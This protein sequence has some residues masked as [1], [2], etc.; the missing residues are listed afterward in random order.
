[1]WSVYKAVINIEPHSATCDVGVACDSCPQSLVFTHANK[2]DKV[3]CKNCGTTAIEYGS[4]PFDWCICRS[5]NTKM[6]DSVKLPSS[7]AL[8]LAAASARAMRRL[9]DRNNNGVEGRGFESGP[10]QQQQEESRGTAA[11]QLHGGRD[12]AEK[13]AEP[14]ARREGREATSSLMMHHHHQQPSVAARG[15]DGFDAEHRG[16]GAGSRAGM[17]EYEFVDAQGADNMRKLSMAAAAERRSGS[18]IDGRSSSAGR[19]GVMSIY[20][21][22]LFSFLA[23]NT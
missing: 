11:A 3:C 20:C 21:S 6:P 8:P 14:G 23:S 2:K 1:M 4:V 9:A 19:Q 15:M 5:P 10:Q 16:E 7:M 12:G 22:C 17:L 13:N 18:M